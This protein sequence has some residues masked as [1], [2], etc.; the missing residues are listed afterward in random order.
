MKQQ[1]LFED[2]AV[3]AFQPR[4]RD[5]PEPEDLAL[6][7]PPIGEMDFDPR[8]CRPLEGRRVVIVRDERL[9]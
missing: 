9:S 1:G 7:T 4:R 6:L 5:L 8:W 3:S 2:A